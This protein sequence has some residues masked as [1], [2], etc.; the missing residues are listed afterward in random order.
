MESKI[1]EPFLIHNIDPRDIAKYYLYRSTVDGDLITPLKMQK[2]VYL[3]YGSHLVRKKERLFEDKIE[4]W[5]NGPVVPR[6]YQALKRYGSAPIEAS[7]VGNV[8]EEEL[9]EKFSSDVKQTLDKVYEKFISKS[10]FELVALTHQ[11]KAWLE[12]RKGLQDT[13]PS[14]RE[15]ED[16]LILESFGG[17]NDS[18]KQ[19]T[20]K[21]P[22]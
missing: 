14:K 10:A 12:A 5:P 20:R 7:F 8:T 21:V 22:A 11:Q 19:K 4:A 6:L 15:L 2:L 13:E 1:K 3:A 18:K 16:E 9:T 17:M